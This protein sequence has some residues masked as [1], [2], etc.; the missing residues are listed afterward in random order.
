MSTLT[1]NK[2]YNFSVY[3]NSILGTT[4]NN[5]KLISILDYHTA[6]KFGNIELIHKQVLPYLPTGTPTDNTKYTYYLFTYKGK[7]VV[8]ADVWILDSS[9]V[10]T[11]GLNYTIRLNNISN[12]QYIIIKNQLRLLGIS[13]DTL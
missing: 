13:F 11:L 5:A 1:I 7:S 3:A 8:L 4:Y 12:S 10:E 6:L 2:Y 9:V